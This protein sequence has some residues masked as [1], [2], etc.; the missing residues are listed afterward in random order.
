MGH[1]VCGGQDGLGSKCSGGRRLR[2]HLRSKQ[3]V[4]GWNESVTCRKLRG[5]DGQR[6]VAIRPDVAQGKGL[7]LR[8]LTGENN[9]V[10]FNVH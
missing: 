8:L 2:N 1:D 6:M 10:L 3:V 7:L 4:G 5:L 9:S